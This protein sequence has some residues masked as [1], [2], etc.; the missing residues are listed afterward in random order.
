MNLTTVGRQASFTAGLIM[1]QTAQL[2]PA[3]RNSGDAV[4]GNQ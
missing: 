4:G 1:R 2:P 3:R